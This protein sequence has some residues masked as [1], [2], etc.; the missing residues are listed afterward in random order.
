MTKKFCII[1]KDEMSS[2][3][4]SICRDVLED[5]EKTLE[6]GHKFHGEVSNVDRIYSVY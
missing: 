2:K 4:C 3:M 1:L 5:D 6:C